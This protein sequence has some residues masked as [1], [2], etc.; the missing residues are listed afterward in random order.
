[1]EGLEIVLIRGEENS[2]PAGRPL[3]ANYEIVFLI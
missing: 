3:I 1:M 2:Y